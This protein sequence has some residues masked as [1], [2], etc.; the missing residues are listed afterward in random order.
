L[1]KIQAV[2]DSAAQKEKLRSFADLQKEKLS[3]L[4]QTLEGTI[5]STKVDSEKEKKDRKKREEKQKAN[6][7]AQITEEKFK[8]SEPVI[9]HLSPKLVNEQKIEIDS[10]APVVHYDIICDVCEQGPIIGTRFKC[11]QC[12]DYDLCEKCE[13]TNHKEHLMLRICTP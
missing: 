10:K 12:A 6:I 11:F 9:V 1:A 5:K 3:E 13:K 4:E 7:N 2:K 8:K